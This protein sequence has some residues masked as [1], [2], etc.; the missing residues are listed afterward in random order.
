MTALISGFIVLKNVLGAGYP[1]VEAITASLPVCDEFLISEG[2]SNDGTYQIVEKIAALNRKVKVI[3]QQWPSKKEYSVIA[4]VTNAV[5]AKCVGDY[6]F[7]IQANEILHEDNV[8]LLKALPQTRPNVN[9]FAL[10]FVH[11]AK[12]RVFYEDFRVRFAKN[13]P[14]IEA[15]IDAWTLGPSKSFTKSE[16]KRCLTHPKKMLQ[17]I[18]KGIEWTYANT[19]SSTQSKAI[20]LPKPIYRYWSLAPRDYLKKCEKHIEMFSLT[21][22]EEDIKALRNHI[23][24]PDVFWRKAAEIRRAELDFHLPDTLGKVELNSHP[25]IMQPLL[26]DSKA[27]SYTIREEVLKSIKDL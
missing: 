3:R 14:C 17:Y 21:D 25:R 4:E 10:P 23:N 8:E 27:E 12:D 11:L 9:A 1:F 15:V 5:R 7:S 13:L 16:T 19:I 18:Y 24:E 26:I 22:L 6:I 2:Y 20:Y